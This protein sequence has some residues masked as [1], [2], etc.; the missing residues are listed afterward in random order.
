MT[1]EGTWICNEKMLPPGDFFGPGGNVLPADLTAGPHKTLGKAQFSDV[2]A[3][4]PGW[5]RAGNPDFMGKL[6]RRERLGA[7]GKFPMNNEEFGAT[8]SFPTT[9]INSRIMMCLEGS[10]FIGC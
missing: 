6:P 3:G 5:L 9:Y 7:M 10:G 4:D 1:P 8:K 2:I